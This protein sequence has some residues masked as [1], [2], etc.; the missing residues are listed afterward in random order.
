MVKLKTKNDIFFPNGLSS[1]DEND[2]K[3][4]NVMNKKISRFCDKSNIILE[5]N[6]SENC[7]SGKTEQN[8]NAES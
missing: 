1:I 7:G 6:E 3:S 8:L 2:P 4:Y 5:R